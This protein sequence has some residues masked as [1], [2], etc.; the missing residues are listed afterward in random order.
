MF[1][2][3]LRDGA[4]LVRIVDVIK[5]LVDECNFTCTPEGVSLQAMDN[6][7]VSLVALN[8]NAGMFEA[9]SCSSEVQLG[10]HLPNLSRILKCS[11]K[12]DALSMSAAA[13]DDKISFEFVGAN[14]S[15]DFDLKLMDIDSERVEIPEDV[16]CEASVIMPSADFG[17]VCKDLATI[18]D[19]VT[20]ATSKDGVKFTTSGEVGTA[21]MSVRPTS[22][23]STEPTSG[24]FALRYLNSF[25][26]AGALAEDVKLTFTN[27]A[28]V[29]V[30]YAIGEGDSK[31]C[32][33]LAPKLDDDDD[34]EDDE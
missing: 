12:D 31:L 15:C 25:A 17:R 21:N 26:R 4:V 9:Y 1:K 6:S 19:T 3:R 28:P 5:D 7:H 22:I 8:M 10:V 32:F 11:S 2:A 30:E 29:C 14:K 33:Y 16:S 18:G 13:D 27:G 23:E 20:I 34:E 24:G